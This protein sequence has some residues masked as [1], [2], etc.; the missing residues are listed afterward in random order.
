MTRLP[1]YEPHWE[2]WRRM[3]LGE[4]GQNYLTGE[5]PATATA[6]SVMMGLNHR[7]SPSRRWTTTVE[8]QKRW[9]CVLI[10]AK[11]GR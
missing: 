5:N 8:A 10:G 4:P 1:L 3:L 7:P 2:G 6:P 9:E 11:V